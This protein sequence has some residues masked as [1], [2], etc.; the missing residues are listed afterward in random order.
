MKKLF[1]I[2]YLVSLFA[3]SEQQNYHQS[4]HHTV[5]HVANQKVKCYKQHVKN[6]DGSDS[7]IFWYMLWTLNNQS[8]YY[9]SSDAPI[10]SYST[11]VWQ[12]ADDSPL[13]SVNAEEYDQVSEQEISQQEMSPE[14]QTE[15]N[16][17]AEYF[18]G[19]TESEMGDYEDGSETNST[20]NSD[21]GSDNSSDGSSSDGGG[22]D[23]GGDGGGGE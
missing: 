21:N 5:R 23:G 19:M 7:F 22:S 2:F 16:E 3:C 14:M 10:T 17:N 13:S 18:G 6:K 15:M 12:K 4:T 11:I 8:C 1:A 20:D 9:Y